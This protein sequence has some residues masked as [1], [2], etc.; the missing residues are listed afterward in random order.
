MSAREEA[1]LFRR[2]LVCCLKPP[3]V[4]NFSRRLFCSMISA[5]K[6]SW[7]FCLPSTFPFNSFSLEVKAGSSAVS[8]AEVQLGEQKGAQ[9]GSTHMLPLHVCL[10]LRRKSSQVALCDL[11][12]RQTSP[13]LT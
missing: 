4:T 3:L 12:C 1:K 10:R 5:L 9:D 7:L 11:S 13:K 6:Q 2:W 8:G